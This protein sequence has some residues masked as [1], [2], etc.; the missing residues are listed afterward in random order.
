M[1]ETP[2][3]LD[4]QTNAKI[5][6]LLLCAYYITMNDEELDER[7]LNPISLYE[8]LNQALIQHNAVIREEL[9]ERD[10]SKDFNQYI[11]ETIL[12]IPNLNIFLFDVT[13]RLV[14]DKVC[15]ASDVIKAGNEEDI[16]KSVEILM[17]YEEIH[18]FLS[19]AYPILDSY[20][21]SQ[22]EQTI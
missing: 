12:A 8:E 14:R 20:I 18:Q 6:L 3:S 2:R 4:Q 11:R 5:Y 19:T 22:Y 16:I 17:S 13:Q 21:R 9:D 1:N 15:K 10:P 7:D